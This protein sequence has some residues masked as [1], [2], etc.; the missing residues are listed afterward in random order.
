MLCKPVVLLTS[1]GHTRTATVTC[2]IF[3][4]PTLEECDYFTFTRRGKT[5]RQTDGRTDVVTVV[6]AYTYASLRGWARWVGVCDEQN[7]AVVTTAIRPQFGCNLTS[8]RRPMWTRRCRFVVVGRRIIT[9]RSIR[10]YCDHS[11]KFQP[12][13]DLYITIITVIMRRTLSRRR[14]LDGSRSIAPPPVNRPPGQNPPWF[15]SPRSNA[16]LWTCTVCIYII[17]DTGIAAIFFEKKTHT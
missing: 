1:R 17:I 5:G 4:P 12:P 9:A 2:K 13:T 15:W 7:E 8:V 6:R 16:P 10:N 14:L 3:T 11:T